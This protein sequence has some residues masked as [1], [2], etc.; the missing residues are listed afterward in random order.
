[1]QRIKILVLDEFPVVV[2]GVRSILSSVDDIEL[3]GEA[4]N[5]SEAVELIAEHRPQIL[6]TDLHLPSLQEDLG[7]IQHVRKT[8]PETAVIV[9][10]TLKDKDSIVKACIAGASGYLP[11]AT[12]R[13]LLTSSIRTVSKGGMVLDASLERVIFDSVPSQSGTTSTQQIGAEAA[14]R[15]GIRNL[16]ARENEVVRL[17]AKGYTNKQIGRDLS[18]SD[19]TAKKHVQRI[20]TKL[21]ASDRTQA[22]VKAVRLGLIPYSQ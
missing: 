15:D 11:K 10:T 1:M 6:L 13:E 2:E 17:M 9:F 19:E 5:C 22:A 7:I 18:I 16:T 20:I 3:V 8:Y 21:G 14:D 4:T 12:S